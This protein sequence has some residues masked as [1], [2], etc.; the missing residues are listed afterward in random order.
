MEQITLYNGVKMPIV[1]YGVYQVSKEECER[2]VM[3]ALD[4][5]YRS[6]DTA[7][8]YFNEEQVGTAIVKSGIPREDIF[9]TTKVWVEH[10]GYEET[11]KSV[12]ESMRKLQTNYLDLVLLHQPFSDCHGAYRALEDLYDEGKLRAIGVS[13]FYPDRLVDIASFSRVKPMVNQVE[14]HPFNQQIEA[15]RW[16]DKYGVQ[17]E[18]WAPFG[19][20]RG[21]LFENPVLVQI[22]EKYKKTTAQII[23]RWHIQ[24]GVVVIPKSTHK[25][26]ME[27]N[28]NVFDFVLEQT[29]LNRISKLDKKQSSFFSHSDPSMVE[30][31]VRMVEERKGK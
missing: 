26:R 7:Q 8:S 13:N 24:R 20:G 11:K 1:G 5:G 6:I 3:D 29:D 23:L 31:F 25:A 17:M 14:T 9:L 15:K 2:C 12:L 16:M 18:A 10:Y 4:V 28:L 30:W 21:G 27:E 22:A 19:E